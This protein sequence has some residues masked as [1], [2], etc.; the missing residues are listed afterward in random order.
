MRIIQRKNKVSVSLNMSHSFFIPQLHQVN[1]SS[2]PAV[3]AN[4]TSDQ[5]RPES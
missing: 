2:S 3:P 5:R 1:E 4:E